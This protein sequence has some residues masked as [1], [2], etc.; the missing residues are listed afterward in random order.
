MELWIRSQNK[1]KLVKIKDIRTDPC[2]PKEII[3]NYIQISLMQNS[4]ELLGSYKTKERALEVL[5]EIE[6]CLSA[7]FNFTGTYKDVDLQLKTK[8]ING[9]YGMIY[10][11]PK[12]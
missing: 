3:G 6:E 8:M 10:E 12:E 9:L 4:Y 7:K 1:T 2:N 5:D 11:M